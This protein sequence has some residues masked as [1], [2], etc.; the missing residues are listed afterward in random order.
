[1]SLHSSILSQAA[2][3]LRAST[4]KAGSCARSISLLANAGKRLTSIET[5]RLTS[6]E[7]ILILH[8]LLLAISHPLLL[9]LP[10]LPINRFRKAHRVV[11][12]ECGYAATN[13][14]NPRAD[15]LLQ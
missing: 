12:G 13:I 9:R 7:E 2:S 8:L 5:L 10:R 3:A 14:R 6:C 4:Y 15:N 11:L 1:M